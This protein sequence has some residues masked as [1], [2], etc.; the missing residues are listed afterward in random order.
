MTAP[1]IVVDG[2][3]VT[4]GGATVL[5]AV[6]L[7]CRPGRVTGLLGPNGSGKTTLLHT[8]AG[9]RRPATGRVLLDDQDVHVLR[10]RER[11]RLL[12]LVEQDASTSLD[13]RVRQVVDLGRIA[14]RVRFGPPQS[15]PGGID[16]VERALATARVD[17]LADR[18][19][20]ALSGGERQRV[21]LARALAQEPSVLLLDEPTNHLDLGHQ[22]DFLERVRGL[23]LTTVAALH[24]LEL[25]AAYCDDLV[26]LDRGRLVAHG[27]VAEVLTPALVAEVYG[28]RVTVEPHP[29]QPRPHVRWE[30]VVR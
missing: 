24:D 5:D 23:G 20:H 10:A 18:P 6:S 3:A 19:W 17:H 8:V 22:L 1:S 12:A 14:H 2:V 16:A 11:A 26:V 29:T 28:V 7:T 4:L 25:A 27:P 30:G 21:H 15:D 9:L 13:L